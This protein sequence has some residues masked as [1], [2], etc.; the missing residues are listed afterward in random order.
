MT[1]VLHRRLDETPP[2]AVSGDG[3]YLID[4]AGKRYIDGSG[5]AAVSCLGHGD[6][7]VIA[8]IQAQAAKL[9]YAHT[10]FFSSEA[11]ESLADLLI[12]DAPEGIDKVFFVSGG[13]EA[14]E[15][16]LKLVRQF[17]IENGDPQREYIIARRQSF[18]GNTLAAL[19]VGGHAQ[20]RA[21][22]T[23]LLFKAHHIAPCFAYRNQQ[24]GESEEA[25]G[26]RAADEL[27]AKIVELGA[28]RVAAFIAETVV[29]STTG[30]VPPVPGYF[31]RIREI[32]DKYG[33]LLVLDEVMCGMGRTGTLHA[34]EQESM[35]P[36]I[37]T[38][39]KG[40]GGGYVPLGAVLASRR[41][42]DTI[43]GGSGFFQHSHTYQ[44][45]PLACAAGLAVLTAI[46]E[47]DLLAN[48]VAR[49]RDLTDRLV[50]RFGDHPHVGD[51]RGRGLFQAI[52][53]VENRDTKEP[54]D[55][56]RRLHA[57]VK[58]AAFER[59]LICYPMGG[60]VDGVRGDHVQLAPPFIATA[61]DIALIVDRLSDAVD[62]A[63][64]AS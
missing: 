56:A 8:A 2:I 19:A 4:A 40:V 62:T 5:G 21:P 55:P 58:K 52:E 37:M 45:H 18:H 43:A 34:C 1:R 7:D 30:C 64:A 27:E 51:I 14:T 46:H 13:S 60:T 9:A 48:V 53:L 11:A 49:G 50:E 17:A 20:R 25:Y 36:D 31:K 15:A 38:V 29:G 39:A 3:M 6:P 42:V 44:G 32:C 57:R 47:R 26:L 23:P 10:S 61:D 22:Y 59:G 28:D 16:A 24:P 63:I 33:V 54:F 35:I 41:V 12:R